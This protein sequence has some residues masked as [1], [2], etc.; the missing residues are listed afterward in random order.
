M[1]SQERLRAKRSGALMNTLEKQT[2]G[3]SEEKRR[4]KGGCRAEE[5]WSCGREIN[6]RMSALRIL[7]QDAGRI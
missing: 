3:A 4:V 6:A 1:K 2:N 5:G 7:C